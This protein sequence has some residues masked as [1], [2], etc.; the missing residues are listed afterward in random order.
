MP[1]AQELK[2]RSFERGIRLSVS[3]IGV[4]Q[5]DTDCSF[6]PRSQPGVLELEQH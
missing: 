2:A 4:H 3:L 5:I 6:L 1:I